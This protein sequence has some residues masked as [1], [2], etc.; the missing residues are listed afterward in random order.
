MCATRVI[1]PYTLEELRN[2]YQR[3]WSQSPH[4]ADFTLILGLTGVPWG[5][6]VG[7]RNGPQSARSTAHCGHA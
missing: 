3:Q 1:S 5:E 7:Q 2:V 4:F 6:V